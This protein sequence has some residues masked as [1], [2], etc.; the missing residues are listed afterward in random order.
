MAKIS[1]YARQQF[2]SAYVGAPEEDTA[3]AAIAKG[4]GAAVGPIIDERAKAFR[5]KELM[6]VDQQ[7]NNALIKYSI[8]QQRI[9]K[10]LEAQYA[11]NPSAYPEAVANASVKLQE[12]YSA[13]IPDERVR[14]RFG[15]AANTVIRRS[16]GSAL[17]WADVK[18]EENAYIAWDNSMVLAS[19]KASLQ[20]D[21]E[22]FRST[23]ST[24][25]DISK[26]NT[27][28]SSATQYKGLVKN[29]EDA[30]KGY[31]RNRAVND[32]VNFEKELLDG[33]YDSFMYKDSAGTEYVLP[34]SGEEK[35]HYIDLSRDSALE[36][37]AR[38]EHEQLMRSEGTT[39]AL[40]D[41]FFDN[42][43]G[44]AEV[45]AHQDSVNSNPE[46]TKEEKQNADALAKLARSIN[47][48]EGVPD[49]LKLFEVQGDA[50]ALMGKIKKRG[51]NKSAKFINELLEINTRT[52]D[53]INNG[54]ISETEGRAILKQLSPAIAQAISKGPSWG[55]P[56]GKYYGVINAKIK[57]FPGI[58]DRQKK[59]V[60]ANAYNNFIARKMAAE[61]IPGTKLADADYKKM[62]LDSFTEVTQNLYPQTAAAEETPNAVAS[63]A[64]GS[65]VVQTNDVSDKLRAS[66]TKRVGDRKT[67]AIGT[68][69]TINGILY[70]ATDRGW[71]RVK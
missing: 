69:T 4:I 65:Q 24:I 21:S 44:L 19:Q 45:L 11:D 34:L 32:S 23:L 31:F 55:N 1:E 26:S 57:N 28:V 16:S 25:A 15:E 64:S 60:Q 48:K 68:T 20:P 22:T 17:Q 5:D 30:R 47:R 63:A 52:M 53:Y 50:V 59:M 7:A 42:K 29:V 61:T 27:L 39:R 49:P 36:L 67:P 35:Q 62:A 46:S 40:A 9:A 13:N 71:E 6:V 56:L 38:K 2:A 66:A 51:G 41:E 3:A 33:K 8:E 70:K 12:Q 54:E 58:T 43:V 10:D 37:R 18:Q 14:A